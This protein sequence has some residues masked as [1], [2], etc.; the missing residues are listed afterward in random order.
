MLQDPA[1]QW[2]AAERILGDEWRQPAVE[3]SVQVGQQD[4]GSGGRL[5][6]IM[7]QARGGCEAVEQ[8]EEGGRLR[9]RTT[10]RTSQAPPPRVVSDRPGFRETAG[11]MQ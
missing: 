5:R 6:R 8:P 7:A 4:S 1:P 11:L 9:R 3:L 2:P 10:S